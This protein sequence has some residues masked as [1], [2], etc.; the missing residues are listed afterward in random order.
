MLIKINYG[1]F[2]YCNLFFP[3]QLLHFGWVSEMHFAR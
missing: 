1:I 2:F 3:E